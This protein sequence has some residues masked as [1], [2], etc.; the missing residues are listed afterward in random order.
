MTG[1]GQSH[2]T[3]RTRAPSAAG[4]PRV[5]EFR[6]TAFFGIISHPNGR[7]GRMNRSIFLACAM[8]GLLVLAAA[9]VS[10]ALA[11]NLLSNGDFATDLSGW[12]FPDAT[13]S[14]SPFDIDG[15]TD[16]GSAH[17]ANSQ[18][19]ADTMLVMLSQCVPITQAGL[20]IVRAWGYA[21]T[22]QSNGHLVA[23]YTLDLHH[24]DCSGGFSAVGGDYIATASQ[25][26]SYSSGAVLR[27][28]APQP[29]MSINV[30]LRVDK[31][32]AGGSFGGY[33]DAISLVRDTIFI[34][35]FE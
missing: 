35:S 21:A 23:G 34:D 12:Q 13:P 15:S 28:D 1:T 7:G 11:Q 24:T 33:F 32:D 19:N 4:R 2:P 17:A 20:Y 27:I 22:G 26:G 8:C 14:W 3:T 31:T 9:P 16:S 6:D 30:L 25:W 18:A 5:A 10:C 29:L